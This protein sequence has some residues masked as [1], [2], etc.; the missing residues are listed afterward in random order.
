MGG[1]A[2]VLLHDARERIAEVSARLQ[3]AKLPAVG[4]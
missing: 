1:A 4:L 2:L 3:S